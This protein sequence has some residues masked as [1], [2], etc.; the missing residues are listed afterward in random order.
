MANVFPAF[1]QA[2]P[3]YMMPE[4]VLQ[5]QQASGFTEALAGGEVLP[6]LGDGDLAVYGKRLELRT[7]VAGGQSAY[8]Q[9]PSVSLVAGQFSTPTYLWRV[10]AEY[11]HHDT[12]S[13]GQWGVALAEAQRL[14]MRQAIFQQVRA[15]AL[16]GSGASGEGLLN[17]SGATTVN[18][19]ADSYGNTSVSTYDNGQMAQFLLSQI[20]ALKTRTNQMGQGVRINILTSQEVLAAWEYQGIVQLTQFQRAGAGVETTAAVVKDIA[21]RQGDEVTFTMDD[22]LKGAASGNADYIIINMPEVK[23][24][25]SQN[26]INTNIFADLQPSMTGAAVQLCDMVA[27]KEIQCPLPGGASDV[28]SELRT[29]SGWGIRPETITIITAPF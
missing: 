15:A 2:H 21:K 14:G 13:A 10:R 12:S 7:Q 17:T 5:Y 3:S 16:F 4:L 11:D 28:L 29:T 6:R 9:L 8:N 20:A 19:P 22:T 26:R 25:A 18:L 27:P 24:P 23:K 1:V